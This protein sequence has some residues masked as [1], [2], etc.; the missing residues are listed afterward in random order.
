VRYR[1]ALFVV[2]AFICLATSSSHA[3]VPSSERDALVALYNSTNGSGWTNRT[4]WLGA[5]GAECSWHGISCDSSQSHVTEVDLIDNG[6]TG[7]VPPE[8]RDL[9]QLTWLDLAGNSVEG[10]IPVELTELSN[11]EFF[12]AY[13]GNRLSGSL[14]E[15]MGSMPALRTLLLAENQLEGRIPDSFRNLTQI[16]ELN[17]RSNRLTGTIP[18]WIGELANL[19]EISLSYNDF[20]GA[21]PSG[22]T[23][24]VGLEYLSLA[25]NRLSGSIPSDIGKLVA[26]LALNLEENALTGDIPAGIWTLTNLEDLR[27]GGNQLTGE[28]PSSVANLALL[29]TLKME[30]NQLS[31][32]I[33][34]AIG[35]IASLKRLSL[36]ENRL[37]GAIPS[38]IGNLTRLDT[39]DLERNALQGSIPP[40]LTNLT[41]LEALSVAYNAL[42]TDDDALRTFINA[43]QEDGDFESTQTVAPTNIAAADVTDRSVLVSW[44]PINY[45]GGGGGYEVDVTP[46]AGGTHVIVTTASKEA[47]SIVVRGLAAETSYV[48]IVRSTTHPH[49]FQQN[50]I[51]SEDSGSAS[52][53]TTEKVVGPAIVD[54]LARPGGLLQVGGVPQNETSYTLAN[55]GDVATSLTLQQDET[56]FTQT[57]SSFTLEPGG[58]RIITVSSVANQ[59]PGDQWGHASPVGNGVPEDLWVTIPLLSVA[60]SAGEAVAV[61]ITKRIESTGLPNTDAVVSATFDNVG[62]ATLNGVLISDAAWVDTPNELIVIRPGERKSVGVDVRR[63]RRPDAEAGGLGSLFATLRL[64]YVDG[65]DS[66]KAAATASENGSSGPSTSLVTVVDTTKP[67]VSGSTIPP[68]AAGEV[69]RFVAGAVQAS[70]SG[71]DLSLSNAYGTAAI[72]DLEIYFQSA[73][74]SAASVASFDAVAPSASLTLGSVLGSVFSETAGDGTLLVRTMDQDKLLLDILRSDDPDTGGTLAESIPVLRSDRGAEPGESVVL[75][76]ARNDGSFDASLFLQEVSG[77]QASALVECYDANGTM[78]GQTSHDSIAPFGLVESASLPRGT[79]SMVVRND[80]DHSSGKIAAWVLVTNPLTHDSWPVADWRL[81]HG[82]DESAAMRVP[83]VLSEGESP[84]RRRPVRRPGGLTSG[85]TSS[86][87]QTIVTLFNPGDEDAIID[88]V[89]WEAGLETGRA[90]LTIKSLET[91][92]IADVSTFLRGTSG[93]STGYVVAERRRGNVALTARLSESTSGGSSVGTGIPVVP[94]TAGLRLGQARVFAG[95]SDSTRDA[96]DA[97]LPGSTRTSVGIAEVTGSEVTVRARL[98]AFDGKSLAGT[99]VAR[100]FKV[101]ARQLVLLDDMARAILGSERETRFGE[102]R[103]LQLELRV[104]AGDGAASV[105]VISTDAGSGDPVLRME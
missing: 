1:L 24:L 29:D 25:G 99:S 27:L 61:A 17:L 76:G 65:E 55:F 3:A 44:M 101:G 46:A 66:G 31:G 104:V 19:S 102:M 39:L 96:V 62:T 87:S 81:L 63:A 71:L 49:G 50:F 57:P 84:S 12:A 86:S 42:V 67:P 85:R 20:T 21:I 52:F 69:V 32:E 95:L 15:E 53:T 93:P 64:V 72:R 33:P 37:T 56:F 14:P 77:N 100:D 7:T 59:P 16:E 98:L 28:I 45:L 4:N 82:V 5:A 6:L 30:H 40:Q 41:S 68:L 92:T 38:E 73:G 75:A 26:L 70:S 74:S 9:T 60:S 90:T 18:A 43:L 103:N 105:F 11:L 80:P 79:T 48:A 13:G 8:I 22:I 94:A 78:L 36:G 91:R 88:L 35:S 2:A 54:V 83:L 23:T 97:A 89:Y 47:D 10:P 34:A 51:R 58:S